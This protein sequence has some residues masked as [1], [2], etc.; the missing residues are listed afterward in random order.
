MRLSWSFLALV[1]AQA[2]HSVEETYGRLY[3]SFPPA[4]LLT[5]LVSDDRHEAFVIL[6]ILIVT[7][8][9]WCF[10]WPVRRG[11]PSAPTIAL[12]WAIVETLNGIGH[13]LWS[14]YNWSY[15]PGVAT[16]PLLILSAVMV[17]RALRR[18]G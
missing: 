7:F 13:T 8:G 2:A 17:A 4:R 10:F 14:V 6:N 12:I 3:E 18:A 5:S 11:W 1:G 9:L 15:T 16:A